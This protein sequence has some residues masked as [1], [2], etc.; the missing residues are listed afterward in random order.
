MSIEYLSA[1]KYRQTAQPNYLDVNELHTIYDKVAFESHLVIV[2]PK[3]TG[4]TLSLQAWCANNE[5]PLV[6]F[7]C[8]EDIRRSNLLGSFILRGDETPFVLGPLTTAFK[9]AND[10]GSCVLVLEELNALT[11][12]MQKLLNST[13]D[14]RRRIEV[15]EAQEIFQLK[16]DAK[17]WFTGTMNTSVYGGVYMLNEDLKSRLRILPIG[18]PSAVD[19]QAILVEAAGIE[20]GFAKKLVTLAGDTRKDSCE[21]AL[22]TRDLVQIAED[23]ER[24]SKETALWMASG[25]F[26]ESDRP[27][28]KTRVNSVFGITLKIQASSTGF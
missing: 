27:Y 3:G 28:F 2:G 14:F 11:P 9:I 12:Q 6:T 23:T 5:V 13:T 4:K 1:D 25:K 26:E 10:V 15:P 22:S 17:L 16:K 7:D 19:E 18:Y 20:R 8:S 24:I 21:Y